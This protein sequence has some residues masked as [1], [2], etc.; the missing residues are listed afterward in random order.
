MTPTVWIGFDG[1]DYGQVLSNEVC[2][3]SIKRWSPNVTVNSLHQ[4]ALR[5][6]GMYYRLFDR[7]ASTEF[8][9]TRFLVPNLCDYRGVAIFCDSDFMW[10]TSVDDIM[11]YYDPRFAVTCVQHEYAECPSETKMSN[12]KQ[13]WYPRKNWSSLMIFNC[14]HKNV[15]NLSL[16]SVNVKSPAYLHRMTWADNV[17]RIPVE[18]NYLVG[19]YPE[20]QDAKIVHW[21][22]GG[23]WFK[24]IWDKVEYA[25]EWFDYLTEPELK[26][27]IQSG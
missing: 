10:R 12:I 2:Y 25:E 8:T 13:E 14:E 5:R 22:D 21:T 3:R 26:R 24:H 1:T 17:G 4:A 18:Y 7:S 19:Y 6:S 15:K 9:Y 11:Q 27:L 20:V 16:E 23:P